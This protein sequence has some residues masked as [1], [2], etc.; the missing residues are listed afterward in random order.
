MASSLDSMPSQENGKKYSAKDVELAVRLGI[1]FIK[2]GGGLKIIADGIN[3]SKDPA[4]VVGQF[5]AQ[6]MG[7]L[8]ESLRSEY[9]ID[10]GIFLA[11]DGWLD[12]IL[13]WI[14]GELGY[15]EDFSDKIYMQT[16]ETIKAAAM[17]PPPAND[18]MGGQVVVPTKD[19]MGEQPQ[20]PTSPQ[21]QMAPEQGGMQ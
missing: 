21:P 20:A 18:E 9:G 10:P 13:N 14:E 15:P 6:V 7:K 11:K 16:L 5:L 1:K 3:K 8:A 4:R 19:A 12:T 17:E 2:E